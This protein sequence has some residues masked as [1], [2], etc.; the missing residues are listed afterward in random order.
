MGKTGD[1]A[2]VIRTNEHRLACWNIAF[3]DSVGGTLYG[4]LC[5]AAEL[6]LALH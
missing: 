4:V 2:K 5:C 3:R 6:L 1:T